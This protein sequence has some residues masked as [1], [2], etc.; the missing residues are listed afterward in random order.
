MI[1]DVVMI[2]L[3]AA[4]TAIDLSAA[5]PIQVARGG[6]VTDKDGTRRATM[7]FAQGTTA[8]IGGVPVTSLS[9]RATEYTVGPTGPKAMPGQLPPASGYTYAVEL[10]A[11]EAQGQNVQFSKPVVTYVE[12]FLNFPVG[13]IVPVGFYDRARAAWVAVEQRQGDQD[14][15][16]HRRKGRPRHRRRRLDRQP[17]HAGRAGHH[18]CG[19]AGTGHALHRGSEPLARADHPLYALG[20]QLAFWSPAGCKRAGRP[21]SWTVAQAQEAWH[22]AGQGLPRVR[23]GHLLPEPG[24]GRSF[25]SR[26]HA[27]AIALPQ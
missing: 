12:N 15:V 27:L 21:P 3:D 11:D 8:T 9:I 18:R 4:V 20:Y 14:P 7:F 25:A 5:T 26:R 17:R 6:V 19:A 24:V 13:G 23:L 10:S 22:A 16:D 2:P 1:D